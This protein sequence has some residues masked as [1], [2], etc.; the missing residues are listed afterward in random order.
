MC[1]WSFRAVLV[2]LLALSTF[3]ATLRPAG[4]EVQYTLVDIGTLA[5]THEGQY[6]D[7]VSISPAAISADGTV[8]ANST[9]GVGDGCCD[10]F[11][12][13]QGN[14]SVPFRSLDGKPRR[15]GR[16]NDY[17]LIADRS[18]SGDAVGFVTKRDDN[19]WD[20]DA[21]IWRNDKPQA[22]P[23]LGGDFGYA[24]GINESGQIVGTSRLVDG[25]PQQHA[26]LW[27]D[28]QVFDLGT[29]GG[30]NSIAY[31]INNAGTIAGAAVKTAVR[32]RPVIWQGGSI[33][34]L[35]LPTYWVAGEALA[36]NDDGVAVGGGYLEFSEAPL[37]WSNGSFEQLPGFAERVTGVAN[38]INGEGLV[39]GKVY[40]QEGTNAGY[41]AVRWDENGVVDLN[42]LIDASS[43]Y[44]LVDA[45]SINDSG[46]ILAT[47]IKDGVQHGVV[48]TQAGGDNTGSLVSIM[49]ADEGATRI[50]NS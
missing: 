16:T 44:H 43:G 40:L 36:I 24:Y 49:R 25:Q 30:D 19:M 20:G 39:V 23:S 50:S 28:G 37:R 14:W 11:T 41:V 12:N 5:G 21:V 42:E 31:D 4:A 38:D 13:L 22:L 3:S 32:Y 45:V 10:L 6:D 9:S 35:A 34:E 18:S 2:G 29:L 8:V 7:L 46:Q 17:S 48:L 15:I 47:A 26:A 27:T 1:S 33:V